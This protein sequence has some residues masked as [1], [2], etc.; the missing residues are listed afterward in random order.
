[1]NLSSERRE[2]RCGWNTFFTVTQVWLREISAEEPN[3][4][5]EPKLKIYE[6]L[7]PSALKVRQYIFLL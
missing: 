7:R 1:M 4:T 6:T 5:E 2:A 3:R